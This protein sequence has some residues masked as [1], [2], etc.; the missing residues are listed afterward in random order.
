MAYY[1]GRSK[2]YPPLLFR[3]L[4]KLCGPL[5]WSWGPDQNVRRTQE[6]VFGSGETTYYYQL[7]RFAAD[8]QSCKSAA[9]SGA[10][11]PK[12]LLRAQERDRLDSVANMRFIDHVR[13]AGFFP[14]YFEG[15]TRLLESQDEP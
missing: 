1:V 4:A 2:T 9:A 7:R 11:F 3:H 14:P 15:E 13:E 6:R 5:L 10:P 8:V 12:S